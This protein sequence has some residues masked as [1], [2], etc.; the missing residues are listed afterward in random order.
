MISQ[1][2]N[3]YKSL[4][5]STTAFVVIRKLVSQKII[6]FTCFGGL[7]RE[8]NP[9]VTS[10]QSWLDQLTIKQIHSL[11][12]NYDFHLEQ[13][14]FVPLLNSAQAHV[15]YLNKKSSRPTSQPI[16][17][18]IQIQPRYSPLLQ[19]NTNCRKSVNNFFYFFLFLGRVLLGIIFI[20]FY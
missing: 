19:P 13:Q 15:D 7:D 16:F 4:N 5:P 8:Y 9:F 11:L 20:L 12:L 10:I 18:Q 17:N 14:N 2:V 6:S 3:T 1:L